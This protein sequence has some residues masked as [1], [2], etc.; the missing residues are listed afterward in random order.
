MKTVQ[1]SRTDSGVLRIAAPAKV[2]LFLEV[3]S[4]R[5]DGFH[6]IETLMVQVGLCD[7]LSVEETAP[8]QVHLEVIKGGDCE[9]FGVQL[10]DS[11]RDNLVWRAA[12]SLRQHTQCPRGARIVL[13]KRIPI[14]AGLGGGSSDA[15]A[16]LRLL[17]LLWQLALPTE[18]L[19]SLAASLGSDVPF[20]LNGPVAWCRGRG[21]RVEPFSG[22]FPCWFLLLSPAMLVST[23]RVYQHVR[24]PEQPRSGSELVVRLREKNVE[25]LR[26]ALFNRLEEAALLAYPQ[27]RAIRET[28]DVC[29]LTHAQLSG[30]GGTL[31]AVFAVAEEAYQAA[32]DFQRHY[33]SRG[34]VPVRTIVVPS[35][36]NAPTPEG[37]PPE[38][39][40]NDPR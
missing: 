26:S 40:Q 22:M 29:G 32:E 1:H 10:P 37:K 4:R 7:T 36:L 9:E 27:L 12:E 38:S 23:A 20:F 16:T 34:G 6:E 28:L 21:E 25:A 11:G 31:F 8:A 24:I 19:M 17:N 33:A 13:E 5:N 3:L 18:E 15:A 35:L 2:N 30:S 14:G 39:A